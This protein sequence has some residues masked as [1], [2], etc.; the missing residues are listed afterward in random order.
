M[1]G[2]STFDLLGD[3]PSPQRTL[4]RLFLRHIKLSLTELESKV[5][6]LPEDRRL[7]REQIQDTLKTLIELGWVKRMDDGGDVYSLQKIPSSH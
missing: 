5:G 7:T 3:M 6:D 1:P 4:V 2:V